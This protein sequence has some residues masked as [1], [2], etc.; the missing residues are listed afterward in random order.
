MVTK[1]RD[2]V[3]IVDDDVKAILSASIADYEQ[4]T[5]KTLQ[6]AH[7]ER[8][9]IQTYAYR[10]LLVRKGINEGF[11][12]Q[13]PQFATGI[14]LDLCGEPMGC[15]RLEN[16]AARCMLRFTAEGSHSLITI[17]A[18]TLVAATDNLFFTTL[19]EVQI[20]STEQ[21]V[22]VE[23]I[24]NITGS[25]GNGWEVGR[26]KTLK[27]AL[28][29]EATVTVSNIDEPSGG[30]ETESDD[31]YRKRI[32]LAPEA[33]TTC[34][35]IGAYE[36]HTRSVSQ[37]ISDVAI[38]TPIGGTVQIAVLTKKGIPNTA[39]INQIQAYI[40][41]EKR[42]TLCDKIKVIPAKQVSYR[43]EATLDL[44]TDADEKTVLA[45]AQQ[46][47]QRYLSERTQRMGLDV[48]PLNIQTAL[49]VEGVYNV[50]LIQP[51]LTEVQGDQWANCNSITLR[52][53]AERKH[54]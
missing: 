37:Y 44:L 29:T 49:Q 1:T 45:N 2:E 17:P 16:Q 30:I 5:G 41:S 12:Q 34:G 48:V 42:R 3:K 6:P 10:E 51:R 26:I 18:G 11:V 13:F 38:S 4:R 8:S 7:I 40:S 46:A 19:I 15:Y 36:Y 50:N 47:V 28:A 52:V 22:D 33:F 23:A 24:A 21:F 31:D 9:I 20:R 53:N 35:T 32:L 43:I 14:A 54:G 25:G 39:L 27:T